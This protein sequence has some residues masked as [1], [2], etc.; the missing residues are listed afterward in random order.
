MV[1]DRTTIVHMFSS[2]ALLP[3]TVRLAPSYLVLVVYVSLVGRLRNQ[4]FPGA[5]FGAHRLQLLCTAMLRDGMKNVA[6]FQGCS[7]FLSTATAHF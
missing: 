6:P 2:L 5:I 4:N 3:Q 1:I 7:P